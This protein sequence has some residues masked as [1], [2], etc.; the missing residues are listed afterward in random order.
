MMLNRRSALALAC[1]GALLAPLAAPAAAD[2]P[3][4]A[5][6]VV[7]PFAPGGGTDLLGRLIAQDLQKR[8]GQTFV[9]ENRPGAAG[10][11]G[12]A[13]VSRSTP[14]GYRLLMA[15]TGALAP[16]PTA[17]SASYDVKAQFS[18]VALAAAPPYLLVVNAD[19][20]ANSVKELIALAKSKPESVAFASSGAGAASH[21]AALLFEAKT[22]TKLLHVPYKGVGPAIT[23]V[24]SGQVAAMFAPPPAA[25]PHVKAGRLKVLGV[26]ST[27]RSELFPDY[28][29]VAEAGV[30]DYEAVGWFGL[31]GPAGMDPAIVGRLN[32]EVIALLGTPE[33]K[34]QLANMGAVPNTMSPAAFAT[35]IDADT[36]K[37]AQLMR[38]AGIELK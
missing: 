15:A 28:P 16:S 33:M 31:F 35:F 8:L 12:A 4:Q 34:T 29:T 24:V 23:D 13:A 11:T 18:P 21:L 9:V 32:K 26:T 2:Y 19:F 6:T 3:A 20:P 5:V 14:D 7:V 36:T 37:W 30:P 22:G 38:A 27:A 10:T 17:A 25:L 1:A